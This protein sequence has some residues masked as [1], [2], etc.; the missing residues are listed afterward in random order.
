[1]QWVEFQLSA[2]KKVH[3]IFQEHAVCKND[4]KTKLV[5]KSKAGKEMQ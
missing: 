2:S 3:T 1:M 4:K 5:I